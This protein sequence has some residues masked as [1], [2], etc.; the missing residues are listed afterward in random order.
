MVLRDGSPAEPA[1]FTSSEPNWRPG[2]R[3]MVNPRLVFRILEVRPADEPE[4][5]ATWV[6]ESA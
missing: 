1:E 6:V 2:D 4:S 3:A 5:S